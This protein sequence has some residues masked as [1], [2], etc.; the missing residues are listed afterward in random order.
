MQTPGFSKRRYDRLRR[1]R[2]ATFVAGITLFL[3]AAAAPAV[4]DYSSLLA[5]NCVT[6]H[7]QVL[8]TAGVLLDEADIG[9]VAADPELWERVVT[10]LSL[11]AM[12]PVGIPRPSED[13]Y[14]SIVGYLRSELDRA[15]AAAPNPGRAPIRRLNRA[16]YRNA[17]HDLL[18]LDIDIA[19]LLPPDN[20]G[21]GFDNAAEALS[22]SPLLMERYVFAAGRISRLAVGPPTDMRPGSDTYQVS[23]D[24]LQTRRTDE[25]YPFGS[26]GGARAKHY[27]PLDA[28]YVISVKLQRNLEGYIRGLQREHVLDVRLD[29]GR[30]GLLPVGGEVHGRPGPVFTANQNP[31]YSGDADQTGYEFGADDELELRVAVSAGLHAGQKELLYLVLDAFRAEGDLQCA[32]K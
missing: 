17:I 27:F 28:E 2:L 3:S 4:T 24:L 26:R 13:D 20:I 5:R 31:M 9:N 14:R 15:A 6:C 29:H 8:R 22:L 11:R 12:P 25:S 7:N 32:T 18:D 30:L 23:R 21:H 1:Y 16:E 19:A 10:K